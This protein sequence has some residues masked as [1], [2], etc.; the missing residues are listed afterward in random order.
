MHRDI[1]TSGATPASS[2]ADDIPLRFAK[3]SYC[4]GSGVAKDT[5]PF[6]SGALGNKLLWWGVADDE[7]SSRIVELVLE[8]LKAL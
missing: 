3:V 6:L 5:R 8:R 1:G 2:F 7:L 4:I